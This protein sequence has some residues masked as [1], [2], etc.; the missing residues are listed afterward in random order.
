MHA[1][2][3]EMLLLLIL[4]FLNLLKASMLLGHVQSHVLGQDAS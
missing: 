1:L 3:K 4:K 2:L